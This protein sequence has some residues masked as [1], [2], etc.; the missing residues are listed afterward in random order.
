MPGGNCRWRDA[1]WVL[2][3]QGRRLPTFWTISA[4][5][6]CT[7]LHTD[8]PATPNSHGQYIK[9]VLMS[10]TFVYT[11]YLVIQL[12]VYTNTHIS[13]SSSF[14]AWGVVGTQAQYQRW[15]G[16]NA[17]CTEKNIM[18]QS[19]FWTSFTLQST[20]PA[21]FRLPCLNSAPLAPSQTSGIAKSPH[22]LSIVFTC[23]G[24]CASRGRKF[25]GEKKKLN[26]YFMQV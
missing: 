13:N 3:S 4:R 24:I 22:Y 5:P 7:W 26:I 19:Q 21:F 17:G 11:E 1:P 6:P 15:C 10:Y 23:F 9:A 20:K 12:V 16:F 25:L 18:L 14:K 2:C 8:P